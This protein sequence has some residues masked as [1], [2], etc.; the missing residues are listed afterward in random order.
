M[1]M[2][3]GKTQKQKFGTYEGAYSVVT[4]RE[5]KDSQITLTDHEVEIV[6][7]LF[8]GTI[9]VGN[10]K[11]S[12]G[13]AEKTFRLYPSGHQMHLNL[14]YPKPGKSELRLYLAAGKGFMPETGDV[15]F[16]FIKDAELWIG[17]MSEFNWRFQL[18]ALTDDTDDNSY[19]DLINQNRQA[20]VDVYNRKRR[21]ALDAMAHARYRC[22]AT[23]SHRLFVSKATGKNY[24]EAHH[25]IPV[26]LG[27]QFNVQLDVIENVVC[28]CPF[29]HRALHHAEPGIAVPILDRIVKRRPVFTTF[30]VT[31]ND[32]YNFYA[33]EKII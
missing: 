9:H 1:K 22:E 25:I 26:S 33:L 12:W 17:N 19:Q 28:L 18:S 21:V 32:L 7:R 30:G 4:D 11:D 15:V 2:I 6:T 3:F 29:C 24:L 14:V 10:V 8:K 23:S 27:S 13:A 20:T 5:I 31:A 16:L